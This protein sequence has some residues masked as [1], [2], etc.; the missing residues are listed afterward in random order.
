MA[1]Q[2]ELDEA[3]S[4]YHKLLTGRSVVEVTTDGVTTKYSQAERPALRAYIESLEI[5]LGTNAA[6][7]SRPMGVA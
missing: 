3:K 2:T 5:E 6:K 7:R 1:T 4:A